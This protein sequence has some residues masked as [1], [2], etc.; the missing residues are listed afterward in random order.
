RKIPSAHAA[1]GFHHRQN[2]NRGF[3]QSLA[4]QRPASNFAQWQKSLAQLA[5]DAD[6]MLDLHTDDEALAMVGR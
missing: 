2:F 6:L 1:R 5:L 4:L 3:D